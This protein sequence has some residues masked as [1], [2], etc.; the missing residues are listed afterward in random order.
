M[1][2]VARYKGDKIAAASYT[3]DDGSSS[4][5]AIASIFES[6]GYRAT[7][8]IVPGTVADPDWNI[9][10]G[11]AAKGH[12][13]GNHSMTHTIDMSNPL[14][15]DQTLETEI[16]DARDAIQQKL[17]IKPLTFA[18]PWHEY[19]D[20]ALAVAERTH[21]S[22][23]KMNI[24]DPNYAFAFL[25][26]MHSTDLGQALVNLNKQLSDMVARGGW[27]VA[28]GH[29]IDGSGWSPVTSQFLIDH[30]NFA[31]QYA[32]RLWVDT[33]LNVARYR[34]C[35]SQVEASATIASSSQAIVRLDGAFDAAV[36]T[37]PLTVSIPVKKTL[38]GEVIARKS[39][40]EQVPLTVLKG[41]V[42]ID[43]R[44]GQEVTLEVR[45]T[46]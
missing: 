11:L 42:L 30:L 38:S 25:D 32:P 29:G 4:S 14:L 9:W 44:P 36:C 35:R 43:L 26:Q 6:F 13:I 45:K 8:F 23:R 22:V 17:G 31:G 33:Y 3:F 37:T 1:Q 7:F 15:S 21:I 40:G 10:K 19:S 12:E 46:P 28:A 5:G 16:V 2:Y 18:F 39:S 20:R 34:L 24:G 27:L 41:K